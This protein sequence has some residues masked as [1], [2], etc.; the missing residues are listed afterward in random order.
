[1]IKI[2]EGNMNRIGV[3]DSG[4]GGLSI[5]EELQKELPNQNF[6]YY[7]DK[8]NHPY[9]NKTEEKLL[10][11]TSEIVEFFQRKGCKIIVIACN[12]ATT[13]CMKKLQSKYPD[14]IFIGT[15]PAIKIAYDKKCQHT[16]IM[17]TP[18]T[19][20][21]ERVKELLD[22]YKNQSQKIELLPC[23]NLAEMIEKGEEQEIEQNLHH[24]L[25]KYKKEK[26]DSIVL[27]CTH[28]SLI[29]KQIQ[30]L[31][32]KAMILDGSK[33]V[34]KEVKHQIKLNHLNNHKSNKGE[35]IILDSLIENDEF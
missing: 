24:L 26:I 7:G 18:A 12:T 20:Q 1:M 22:Q 15:V 19:I 21:S 8:K 29:K 31:F 10:Q 17:A 23:K 25:D 16:I 13:R 35:V 4:I 14:I 11:I 28:Y 2:K 34:A 32:P 27:G 33:G 3:F 6:L 30:R 5:L 9:G